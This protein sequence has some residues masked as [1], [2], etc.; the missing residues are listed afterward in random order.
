MK[1]LV[2]IDED[3]YGLSSVKDLKMQRSGI[4]TSI[5]RPLQL[6]MNITHN[7]M[8]TEDSIRRDQYSKDDTGIDKHPQDSIGL[9]GLDKY[10]GLDDLDQSG[11]GLSL[12]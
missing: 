9:D 10:G 6:T 2:R 7:I 11:M 4:P 8:H 12:H 5:A 1:N 3:L